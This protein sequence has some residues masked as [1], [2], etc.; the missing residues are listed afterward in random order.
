MFKLA[1]SAVQVIQVHLSLRR[2]DYFHF[3]LSPPV[4]CTFLSSKNQI[5]WSLCPGWIPSLA[6]R[7]Q[8]CVSACLHFSRSCIAP[9]LL[10]R[11]AFDYFIINVSPREAI[12]SPSVS[13]LPSSQVSENRFH[14]ALKIQE[15]K[16]SRSLI[17][18][19][20]LP[21]YMYL[22]DSPCVEINT[23]R[24]FKTCVLVNIPRKL[25]SCQHKDAAFLQPGQV[26]YPW[27][28]AQRHTAY[29]VHLITMKI[30]P[31]VMVLRGSFIKMRDYYLLPTQQAESCHYWWGRSDWRGWKPQ[32][33]WSPGQATYHTCFLPWKGPQ[34]VILLADSCSLWY[35][36][37]CDAQARAIPVMLARM[38]ETH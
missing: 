1:A 3:F 8:P 15:D 16:E 10:L 11:D 6:P 38:L 24:A 4:G 37:S 31:L 13:S 32:D 7:A 19:S 34:R 35:K 30:S 17:D 9:H 2:K 36:T 23:D 14:I 20:R 5:Y 29:L 28:R 22:R 26:W 25:N 18:R 21:L 33:R 27:C 12:L